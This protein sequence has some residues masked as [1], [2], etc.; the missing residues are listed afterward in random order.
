MFYAAKEPGVDHDSKLL[1]RNIPERCLGIRN[2]CVVGVLLGW[3]ASVLSIVMGIYMI[4]VPSPLNPALKGKYVAIANRGHCFAAGFEGEGQFTLSGH[5]TYVTPGFVPG[6][7]SLCLNVTAN[8]LIGFMGYAHATTLRWALIQ[9]NRFQINS[10]S[11]ILSN[12]KSYHPNRWYMNIVLI[13]GLGITF[14]ALESFIANTEVEKACVFDEGA[15]HHI[16]KYPTDTDKRHGLD[17]IGISTIALGIGIL[18]QALVSTCSLCNSSIVATW[19]SNPMTNAKVLSGFNIYQARSNN[20][21]RSH[22]FRQS[23]EPVSAAFGLS[24]VS[25]TSSA[26]S[27]DLYRASYSFPRERQPPMIYMLPNAC[28]IRFVIWAFLGIFATWSG[29]LAVVDSTNHWFIDLSHYDTLTQWRYWGGAYI[30]YHGHGYNF[31]QQT[32]IGLSIQICAQS[33]LSFGLHCVE[34]L[35]DI[36]RDECIWRKAASVGIKLNTNPIVCFSTNWQSLVFMAFKSV[37][38]WNFGYCLIAGSRVSMRLSPLI[39][40]TGLLLILCLFME[41]LVRYKPKGPQ[42]VTYGDILRLSYFIDEWDHEKIFWGDKGEVTH[43]IRKAGI[44]GRRLSDLR[45]NAP[46]SGLVMNQ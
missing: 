36:F 13:V 7:V 46:Y 11:R 26:Q 25:P 27:Q 21:N 37:I 4:Y 6:L 24:C 16:K 1:T 14:G 29:I 41:Y 5:R 15:D 30:D 28:R 35:F 39:T 17:F 38:H 23:A 9:E 33:F 18:L 22:N 3:V 32:L 20:F 43:G 10:N 42:P 40:M 2:I 12:T 45:P 34:L 19:S 8:A 44:S 31:T